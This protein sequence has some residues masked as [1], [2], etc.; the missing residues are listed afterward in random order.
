MG[1]AQ[2][3]RMTELAGIELLAAERRSNGDRRGGL[4]LAAALEHAVV[5]RQL[6]DDHLKAMGDSEAEGRVQDRLDD[7][8]YQAKQALLDHL[9]DHHGIGS[10]LA[11]KFGEIL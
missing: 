11:A 6:A 2:I 4:P 9:L 3:A 8:A 10:H 5:T 7:A 1:Q